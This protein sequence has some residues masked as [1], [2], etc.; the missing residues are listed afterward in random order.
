MTKTKKSILVLVVALVVL[1]VAGLF[2]M[3]KTTI[4]LPS[5]DKI[6][7]TDLESQKETV[8]TGDNLS[9][10]LASIEKIEP[11][12]FKEESNQDEPSVKDAV[13]VDFYKGDSIQDS[14]R[15]YLYREDGKVKLMQ[16]YQ[17][18][19]TLKSDVMKPFEGQ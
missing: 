15:L 16:P 14:S 1:V 19:V 11:Y 10:F 8:L 3:R 5:G 13:A 6:V 9:D 2:F 4:D 18:T 12:Y 7:V 17:L